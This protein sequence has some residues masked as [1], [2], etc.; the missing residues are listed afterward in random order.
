[1][2]AIDEAAPRRRPPRRYGST[3]EGTIAASIPL[4]ERR[5][6]TLCTGLG[7]ARGAIRNVLVLLTWWWGFSTIC[8]FTPRAA[9]AAAITANASPAHRIVMAGLL[10]SVLTEVRSSF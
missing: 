2:Y 7:P 6:A 8:A 9:L 4:T 5:S 3:S 10:I 1:M